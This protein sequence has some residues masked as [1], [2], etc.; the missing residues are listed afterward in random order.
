MAKS[1]SD[2]K[3]KKK[4][5]ASQLVV[6]VEKTERDQF[7][8]LCKEQGSTAGKEIRGF[9]RD[10]IDAVRAAEADVEDNNGGAVDLPEPETVDAAKK[11]ARKPAITGEPEE[12]GVQEKPRKK[13]K[14]K[15]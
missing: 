9:M 12:D 2:E 6:R 13:A 14:A 8:K 11:S 4:V 5:K 15:A 3:K 10:R 7:V 1:K